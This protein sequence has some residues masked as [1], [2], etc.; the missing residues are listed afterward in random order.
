VYGAVVV[1]VE[2]VIAV[3]AMKRPA[4]SVAPAGGRQHTQLRL[5][6]CGIRS[7]SEASSAQVPSKRDNRMPAL[8]GK[9]SN[10]AGR[11][12]GEPDSEGSPAL[13][14]DAIGVGASAPSTPKTLACKLERGAH[15]SA[16]AGIGAAADRANQKKRQPK[17]K[18]Q[19][20]PFKEAIHA[21]LIPTGPQI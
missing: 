12:A 16:L 1:F 3:A 2:F 14:R 21:K 10:A 4:A 8:A 5:D 18:K 19:M 6:F 20:S 13:L 11:A 15:V 7:G 9:V 17:K